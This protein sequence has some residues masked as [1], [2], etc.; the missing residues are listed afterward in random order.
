MTQ[1][2]E[3]HRIPASKRPGGRHVQGGT[4]GRARLSPLRDGPRSRGRC[5]ELP[6]ASP[7][8][9]IRVE[10]LWEWWATSPRGGSAGTGCER[11]QDQRVCVSSLLGHDRAMGTASASPLK[12][13]ELHYPARPGISWG[14][15]GDRG[16]PD[17]GS[18]DRGSRA[19]Y[20]P[21]AV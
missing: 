1:G 16:A 15:L 18:W 17:G 19:S 6:K 7:D 8:P 14:L 13:R 10:S 11:T 12:R 4:D 5:S 20:K 2:S 21:P 3:Q 9:S